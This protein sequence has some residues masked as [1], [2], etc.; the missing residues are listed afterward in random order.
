MKCWF[1][2]KK[3]DYVRQTAYTQAG[4]KGIHYKVKDFSNYRSYCEECKR[5]HDEET[6]SDRER[7]AILKKKVMYERAL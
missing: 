2:G 6:K 7:Y 4:E 1:C 3:A 5:K